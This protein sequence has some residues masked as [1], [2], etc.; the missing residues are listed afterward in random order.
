[1]EQKLFTLDSSQSIQG[2]GG[3]S[4]LHLSNDGTGLTLTVG[5]GVLV[6]DTTTQE[7]W[8]PFS[9]KGESRNAQW[10]PD[11]HLLAAYVTCENSSCLGIWQRETDEIRLLREVQVRTWLDWEVPLWTP[12][13]HGVVV[14][15]IPAECIKEPE[16]G[17]HFADDDSSGVTV[18][19]YDPEAV[20]KSA[21]NIFPY[22]EVAHSLYSD[23]GYVNLAT[24][25][26]P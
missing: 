1:V 9:S 8:Q 23:L 13:G 6:V 24:G 15:L 17:P 26:F 19:S 16:R 4:P 2:P 18:F 5:G 10:S 11:G 20:K 21:E 25:A 22:V 3:L 14:R 12:D 7:R